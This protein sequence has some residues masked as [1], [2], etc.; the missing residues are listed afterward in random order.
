MNETKPQY[1]HLTRAPIR[2]ALIDIQVQQTAI[3]DLAV[4]R[5]HFERELATDYPRVEDR[6]SITSFFRTEGQNVEVSSQN[7]VDGLIFRG[8]ENTKIFQARFDGFTLNCLRPYDSFK[9]FVAEAQR[10]WTQY[11]NL[12]ESP[13]VTRLGL[14]Y[15]NEMPLPAPGI[16][17]EALNEIF[18]KISMTFSVGDGSTLGDFYHRLASERDSGKY[19]CNLQLL[20]Q[21]QPI[22]G[23][24]L[25]VFDIDCFVIYSNSP[26]DTEVWRDLNVLRDWKNQ[27]FF[28]TLRPEWVE[29]YK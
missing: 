7:A 4:V 8:F 16:T 18:S 1:P 5:R 22:T 12:L 19:K 14:R 29:R 26:A 13:S 25:L 3:T 11:S 27:I 15:I 24:R 6:R 28:E 9:S 10:L 23:N 17:K 21:F 20:S 2:E